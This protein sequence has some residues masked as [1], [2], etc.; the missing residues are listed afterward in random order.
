MPNKA[1][2]SSFF[3]AFAMATVDCALASSEQK[4]QAEAVTKSPWWS[5]T[6]S[7]ASREGARN[8]HEDVDARAP[9]CGRRKEEF[10]LMFSME[11][12]IRPY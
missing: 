12:L 1:A 5:S 8:T 4:D 9:N 3:Q 2:S 10:S 7:G 11:L 6:A